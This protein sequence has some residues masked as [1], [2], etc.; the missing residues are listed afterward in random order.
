MKLKFR[1]KKRENNDAW[2]FIFE[3]LEPFMWVAGQSMRLEIPAGYDTDERRFT[4]ASAPYEQQVMITTRLSGSVFK[5]GL[6]ALEPGTLVAAFAV[7][8]NFVWGDDKRPRVLVAAGI[9]ITPFRSMLLQRG[10]ERKPLE[11]L[12]IYAGRADEAVYEQ[13]LTTLSHENDGFSIEYVRNQ[14]F[15][16]GYLMEGISDI[17]EKLVYISGPSR[18]VDEVSA[19]LM[20][21]YDFLEENIK[22]DRFTGKYD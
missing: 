11:G 6:T 14:R 13:E 1:S 10:Y 2:S 21:N 16:A 8:G 5:Q 22:R 12:L 19:D 3:P 15:S 4:I 18:M 17:R 20:V 9:G 7:E